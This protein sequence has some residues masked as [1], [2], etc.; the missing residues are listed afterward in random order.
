M[1]HR[2]FYL[3]FCYYTTILNFSRFATYF[4]YSLYFDSCQTSR[5]NESQT[6]NII[7]KGKIAHSCS[8][9]FSSRER[10]DFISGNSRLYIT[11]EYSVPNSGVEDIAYV[12]DPLNNGVCI[13]MT[14]LK[15]LIGFEFN[16]VFPL[17]I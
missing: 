14:C 15:P 2:K 5:T 10:P 16:K 6:F 11:M 17:S 4:V 8:K 9:H 1:R 7:H 13:D 12:S 3:T